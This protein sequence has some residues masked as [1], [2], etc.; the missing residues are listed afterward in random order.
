MYAPTANGTADE[1][2]RAHPQITHT[3]P[4]VATNSLK[5]CAPPVLTCRAALN[6]ASPNMRCATATPAKAPMSWADTYPGT[7]RHASPPCEAS[8]S[9]TAGLKCAPEIGPK[10]EDERNQHRAG[11][12]RIGQKRDCDV[13]PGQAFAHDARPDNG[14]Q[15][16]CSTDRL[17]SDAPCL[18]HAQQSGA[19]QL[20]GFVARM[21]APMNLPCTSGAIASR[22]TSCP[23]KNVR[24]SSMS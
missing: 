11:R 14:G 10:V 7:S 8:A 19:Q 24:A 20:A 21:K 3:S 16:K 9:V 15:Q 23:L 18:C 2:S 6:T 12:Q 4:K 5:I 17:R 13:S 22:S 1:R